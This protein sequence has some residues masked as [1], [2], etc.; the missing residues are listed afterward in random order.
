[1]A[2]LSVLKPSVDLVAYCDGD[3]FVGFTFTVCTD[4]YLYVNFFVVDPALRKRGYG[5]KLFTYLQQRYPVP[6]ICEVKVPVAGTP[7][8]DWDIQRV[9]ILE[10]SGYDF[11]D[12][13]YAITNPSGITYHVGT[14]DGSFDRDA[15]WEIFDH[16]SLNPAAILRNL[17]RRL[18]K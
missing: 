12:G 5:T 13:K 3:R 14:T 4:R 17:R 18:T 15:Y 16:L 6:M 1:M 8:Y 9:D 11:F 7:T 10:R 2:L